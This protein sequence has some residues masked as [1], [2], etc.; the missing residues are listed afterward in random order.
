[1]SPWYYLVV[2]IELPLLL[3]LA[4]AGG[5]WFYALIAFITLMGMGELY[6]ALMARKARPEAGVGYLLA[7]LMLAVAQFA[8]P[9]L[10]SEAMIACIFAAVAAPLAAQFT[11]TG[12][13]GRLRDAAL[14][15]LGVLYIALPMSFVLLLCHFDIA[16]AVTGDSDGPFKARVGALLMVAAAVWLSDTAAWGIGHLWGRTKLAPRLSPRKSVEG[17][18]AGWLMAVVTTIGV[19]AWAGLPV[20]HGLGLGVLLGLAAQV[21]DLAESVIKRDLGLR[22]FGTLLGPHG[23]M[24]DTFDGMLFAAPIA[25]LYLWFFVLP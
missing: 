8:R 18:V 16:E 7:L 12:V 19:G 20:M 13:P 21:G 22:D 6:S 10:W 1:M 15:T 25:W 11:A 3:A 14:T 5:W 2:L 24:L 17:A 4:Y 23:G 9:E